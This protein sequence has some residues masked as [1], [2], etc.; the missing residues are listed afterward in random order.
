MLLVCSAFQNGV[1]L[2]LLSCQVMLSGRLP[3]LKINGVLGEST[4]FESVWN[5]ICLIKAILPHNIETRY[6]LVKHVEICAV[7]LNKAF[8]FL[9]DKCSGTTHGGFVYGLFFK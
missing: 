9:L 3:D 2:K 1:A 7:G 5:I 6:V 4:S 8:Y